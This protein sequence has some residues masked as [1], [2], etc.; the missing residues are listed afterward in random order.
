MK[1]CLILLYKSSVIYANFILNNFSVIYASFILNS[2][3]P[4][5]IFFKLESRRYTYY[6][7]QFLDIK[8]CYIQF[9]L[10]TLI[11]F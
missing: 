11:T 10:F 1:F 6:L 7:F 3:S 4:R 8:I 2:L 5:Q 9:M